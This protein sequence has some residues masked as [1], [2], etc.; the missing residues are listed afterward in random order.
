[1]NA[2]VIRFSAI[3]RQSSAHTVRVLAGCTS[4]PLS[5]PTGAPL[6]VRSP[7]KFDCTRTPIVHSCLAPLASSVT[8]RDEV[9]M[10]RERGH[11]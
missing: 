11:G 7:P 10:P 4:E 6:I 3:Q 8:L 1:M 5:R 2:T 9:P